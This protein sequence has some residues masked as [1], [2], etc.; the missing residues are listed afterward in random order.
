MAL[1]EEQTEGRGR[2]GRTW[3]SPPRSE[4][5]LL[6]AARASRRVGAPPGADRRRGGSRPRGDRR[7]HGTG[8][9]DQAP[10]RHPDR[11]PQDRRDPRRGAAEDASSSE[12]ASTSTWPKWTCPKPTATSLLVETGAE[13]DRAEL[14]VEILDRLE[15]RYDRWS[16]GELTRRPSFPAKSRAMAVNAVNAPPGGTLNFP[17]TRRR[18]GHRPRPVEDDRH[19]PGLVDREPRRRP[20]DDLQLRP[21]RVRREPDRVSDRGHRRRHAEIRLELVLADPAGEAPVPLDRLRPR[22]ERSGVHRPERL[23]S[24][25]DRECDASGVVERELEP[26]PCRAG[27]R[28]SARRPAA[29]P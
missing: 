3:V 5:S 15:R 4:P 9:G 23:R 24:A 16:Y 19:V 8:A 25:P 1:T 18:S 29:R 27:R 28:C 10:E 12:S 22:L 21:R 13:V 2:L 14:L 7:G 17:G 20:G 6:G 11:G 26:G